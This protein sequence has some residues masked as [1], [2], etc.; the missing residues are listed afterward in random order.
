MLTD[1][2]ISIALCTY[3][4]GEYLLEQL[5]SISS[6]SRLPDEL[7]I[8]DDCSTDSTVAII[9]GFRN[10]VS[11]KVNL[12][13]NQFQ[14]GSTKNF[15]K[16][17]GYCTGDII[18]LADQDDVWNE[19]KIQDIEMEFYRNSNLCAVFTNAEIVDQD[20]NFMGYDLWKSVGFSQK[21]QK[22]FDKYPERILLKQNVVTG[23]TMAF[24]G[25]LKKSLLPIHDNWVHDAW[26]SI[27]VAVMKDKEIKALDKR[28]I[29]Y[30]QHANNQLGALK[31]DIFSEIEISKNKNVKKG[32][33]VDF[34]ALIEF[35]KPKQ[36]LL[37]REGLTQ[38][39]EKNRHLEHRN[40]LHPEIVVRVWK[41]FL[42]AM[43]GRYFR[44]SRGWKS[45]LRDIRYR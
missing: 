44:F 22:E 1:Y 7:V 30:R 15:E 3:N 25:E 4:G 27:I 5:D 28:L 43:S 17:I 19:N 13:I 45:I 31:K 35:L 41:V 8:C 21:S 14:M 38:L 40:K 9:N 29:K 32:K 18:F 37:K 6:Q 33:N 2:K 23:A 10:R 42:E 39:T 12:F 11:F 20:L 34:L 26:I 24:R 16:A 36:K